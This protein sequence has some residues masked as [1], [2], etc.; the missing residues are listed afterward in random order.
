[1]ARAVLGIVLAEEVLDPGV[2][3]GQ[4]GI[5]VRIL[6]H[7][8]VVTASGQQRRR[9]SGAKRSAAGI[10]IDGGAGGV[11]ELAEGRGRGRDRVFARYPYET[12]R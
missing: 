1:M 7:Q 2:G 11:P 4:V 3:G 6:P 8:A 10:E 9:G 12:V 5:H